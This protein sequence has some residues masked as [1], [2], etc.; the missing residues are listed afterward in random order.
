MRNFL[1]P[2]LSLNVPRRKV[3]GTELQGIGFSYGFPPSDSYLLA[4]QTQYRWE[5]VL[6]PITASQ[7]V[8]GTETVQSG[9][10]VNNFILAHTFVWGHQ[11]T[12]PTSW[13]T[14]YERSSPALGSDFDYSKLS[15]NLSQEWE[16]GGDHLI[17]GEFLRGG[18]DGAAPT[19][20][21]F[22]LGGPGV[23][24]GYPRAE[25]LLHEQFAALRLEYH[26]VIS[27]AIFGTNLQTRRWTAILFGDVGKGWQNGENPES[28]PQRQDIGLGLTIDIDVIGQLQAP[29]RMEIAYPINDPEFK[30]PKVILFQTLSLF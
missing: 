21:H 23:L 16:F 1:A 13:R 24:R 12:H 22:L 5:W 25:K 27:R 4:V 19:T 30:N 11:L 9:T 2:R 3:G 8:D 7:T 15:V 6:N 18:I 17:I 26:F 14:I 28:Q 20:K 10:N 29:I